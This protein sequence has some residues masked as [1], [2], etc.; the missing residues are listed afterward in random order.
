MVPLINGVAHSWNNINLILFGTPVIGITAIEWSSKQDIN[1]NYGAGPIP[2]S[3]GYGKKEYTGSIE[4]YYD[5]WRDIINNAPNKDPLDIPFF[6]IPVTFG[7]TVTPSVVVLKACNFLEAP[8][9]V[10]QGDT[11]IKVKI[12]LRI[13]LIENK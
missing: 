11:M 6:D 5:T 1:D 10:N 3:R 12:P 4:L 8:V 9:S 7:G 2:V 13:A